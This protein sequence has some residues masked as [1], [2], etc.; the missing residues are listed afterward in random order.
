MT[1]LRLLACDDWL[2][3]S[4][5]EQVS[6]TEESE[7]LCKRGKTTMA[8][9]KAVAAKA[10]KPRSFSGVTRARSR[11]VQSIAK[12]L[13]DL[14]Y[15]ELPDAQETFYGGPRPMAMYR[16][17]AD[18][19]WIQPQ[20]RWCNIYFLRGAELTDRDWILEGSSDRFKYAKV[21]SLDDVEALPLRA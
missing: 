17:T 9:K 11:E 20:L 10:S 4:A 21:R 14:V 5:L 8:K 6:V 1:R 2:Q 7:S 18:V 16:T 12:A 13:R 15:E 19:C 3:P